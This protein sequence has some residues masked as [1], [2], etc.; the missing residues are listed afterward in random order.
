MP[1][2]GATPGPKPT[3]MDAVGN[4]Y[5]EPSSRSAGLYQRATAVMPGGNTRSTVFTS[6]YPAYVASAQGATVTD[7][8]GQRR[9]DFINNYT[10]LIHGHA[11]PRIIEAVGRQLTLGTAYSFPTESEVRL[12]ELLVERIDSVEH[13]RFTNSG[14]E[15]VMMAIQAARA[16]TGRTRIARFEGCYHGMYDYPDAVLLPFNQPDEVERILQ[17]QAGDLAAV[18]VDPLPHRPGFLDPIDDFLPRLRQLTRVL[19]ILLISDEIISFRL[20]YHGAQRRYGYAA[21]ITTL[22]KIIGGGF[23]IGA[24]G[25][26]AD[27]MAVFNPAGRGPQV[28]HGGTYNANPVTLI[29]GYEAMAMLTHEQF[30]RLGALGQRVRDGLRDIIETRG[31]SWQVSGQASLFK[32]HPH[33]RP[34]VDYRSARPTQAEEATVAQVYLA[35]L[36]QGFVLTPELAGSLSTP[37]SEQHVDQLVEAV[38][39]VFGSLGLAEFY[40]ASGRS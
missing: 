26:R 13:M 19:D 21:D 29:A 30:D 6:P 9:V 1:E 25:G 15:A 35:L 12:A 20:D 34:L 32:L 10:A 18:L 3:S 17:Q 14:T 4:S 36:G 16:F 31:L 2:T 22:G 40:P 23:P 27:V 5:L 11:H 7:V 39:R 24:F 37:M 28:A 33:P 38:D 8:D